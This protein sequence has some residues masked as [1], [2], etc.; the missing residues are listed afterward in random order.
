M[1]GARGKRIAAFK[2]S[3][4][5]WGLLP[6]ACASRP[7]G[8][9]NVIDYRGEKIRLTKSYADFDDYKNDPQN[10]DPAETARVQRL[11]MEAPLERD[12]ESLVDAS[13]AAGEIAFPG[14]GSGGFG[15]QLQPDGTVLTGFSIEIPRAEK[16]RYLIF[17]GGH[18]KYRLIDD[19]VLSDKTIIGH[20]TEENGALVYSTHQGQRLMTRPFNRE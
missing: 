8:P 3:I 13:K 16:H 19:F 12:F 10:I 20:V 1:A 15:E 7:V 11:V 17:R 6:I 5:A 18:G 4:I 14:Y 9:T 2:L